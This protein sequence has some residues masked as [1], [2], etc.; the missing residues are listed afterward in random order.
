MQ[1]F[2]KL[3]VWRKAHE[4]TLAVYR[5]TR[6]FPADEKYGLTSQLRR[7]AL[8]I[9][10]NIAEGTGRDT[11]ADFRRFL[12]IALGSANEVEYYLILSCDL[13]YLQT[14]DR[15]RLI[16]ALVEVRKMLASLSRSLGCGPR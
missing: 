7:A 3:K 16:D 9:A 8:S 2:R 15:D 4:L 10:A 14:S 13:E 11:R 1:D 12:Q 5:Q 6:G